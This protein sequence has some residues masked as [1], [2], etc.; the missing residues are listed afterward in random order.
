GAAGAAGAA[1]ARDVLVNLQVKQSKP[2]TGILGMRER[3]RPWRGVLT[4]EHPPTGGTAV[5]A[6]V[7]VRKGG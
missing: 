3:L 6:E 7:A 1:G 4:V 2:G 5:I